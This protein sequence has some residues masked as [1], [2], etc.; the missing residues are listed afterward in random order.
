MF[1]LFCISSSSDLF[2]TIGCS[3]SA[4]IFDYIYV[5]IPNISFIVFS[6]F[7]F[8]RTQIFVTTE[9]S[10]SVA[11]IFHYV[12]C[13]SFSTSNIPHLPLTRGRDGDDVVL[14]DGDDDDD[15][16]KDDDDYPCSSNIPHLLL[17]HDNG[18][19]DGW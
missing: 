12:D 11:C 15:G 8:L 2:V 3:G 7:V 6:I 16:D 4:C 9:C 10:G 5:Y 17:N 13:S 14:L 18:D 1:P 19:G